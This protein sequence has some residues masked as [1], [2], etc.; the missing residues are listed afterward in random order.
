MKTKII[1]G[2]ATLATLAL[3]A[4]ADDGARFR[5]RDRVRIEHFDRDHVRYRRFDRD[6]FEYRGQIQRLC[7]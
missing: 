6:R 4:M 5:D 7:R 2:L 1:L 3:P